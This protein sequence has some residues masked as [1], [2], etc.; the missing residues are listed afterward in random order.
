MG[1]RKLSNEPDEVRPINQYLDTIEERFWSKVDFNGPIV[2]PELGN[3]WTWK[4]HLFPT[5]HGQFCVHGK[6]VKAHRA[7][8]LIYYGKLKTSEYIC[9]DCDNASC[10]RMEHTYKGSHQSNMRDLADRKRRRYEKCPTSKLTWEIVRDIRSS[11]LSEDMLAAKHNLSVRTIKRV[12]GG[13]HWPSQDDP[14]R[15]TY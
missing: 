5:G 1:Q 3:C 11:S 14:L 12:V 6:D 7:I 13:K 8:W 4:G 2:K 9:H 10:V 15:R